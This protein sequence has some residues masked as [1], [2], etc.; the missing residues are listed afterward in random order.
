M[1]S[2]QAPNQFDIIHRLSFREKAVTV[3][4]RKELW[5]EG[6]LLEAAAARLP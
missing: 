2:S 3:Q 6:M 5:K 4:P 1:T